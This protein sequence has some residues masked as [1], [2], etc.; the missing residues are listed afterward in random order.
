MNPALYVVAGVSLVG[1][2]AYL[3][4]AW[5]YDRRQVYTVVDMRR[6]TQVVEEAEA[7]V[8]NAYS[9]DPTTWP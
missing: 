6:S 8:R 4:S 1:I 7:I 3:Y 5:R 2:A 9:T